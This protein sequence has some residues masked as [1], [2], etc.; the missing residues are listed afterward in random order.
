ME[1][2]FRIKA[3]DRAWRWF[4]GRLTVF[5]RLPS[6]HVHEIIGSAQDI[7]E[8]KQSEQCLR[9]A[10]DEKEALLKEVHHRVK[11]NLQ[12]ITSLLNLQETTINNKFAIRNGKADTPNGKDRPDSDFGLHMSDFASR[13]SE[14][15][16]ETKNRVRSMALLHETLYRSEDLAKID[17]RL[18]I[19]SL[20]AQLA[21][22]YGVD[23]SRVELRI[24]VAP[25]TLDLD[26]ALPCGLVI[27]ELVSNAFKYAFPDLVAR[28]KT[29]EIVGGS[30]ATLSSSQSRMHHVSVGLRQEAD[31]SY[32]LTVSDDGVGLP[33]DWDAR[34]ST[35]LGLRLVSDLTKQI[36]GTLLVHKNGGAQ[37][38]IAFPPPDNSV[39]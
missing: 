12:I 25:V 11:N 8:R 14:M 31:K 10:L 22:S 15:F 26:R 13:I 19:E 17:L 5:S 32:V 18:Y 21:R 4:V 30:D 6:G 2:E 7:T 38:I 16:G 34:Q 24:E 35:S 23:R 36:R 20:C 28:E 27:N 3:S 1:A 39:S 9:D 37:F 33:L 29:R